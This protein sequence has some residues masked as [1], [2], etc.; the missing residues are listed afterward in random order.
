MTNGHRG[1]CMTRYGCFQSTAVTWQSLCA[2]CAGIARFRSSASCPRTLP[3]LLI[4]FT[5]SGN[6]FHLSSPKSSLTRR[7]IQKMA[8]QMAAYLQFGNTR[9]PHSIW[10]SLD[11]RLNSIHELCQL[12]RGWG[13]LHL[14]VYDKSSQGHAVGVD[15]VR[16]HGVWNGGQPELTSAQLCA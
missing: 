16:S 3:T 15:L 13:V 4:K 11:G 1:D 6:Y 9:L 10:N 8:K 14:L 12:A 5:R 7:K 2:C